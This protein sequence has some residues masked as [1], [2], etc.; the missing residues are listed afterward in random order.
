MVA[1]LLKPTELYTLSGW[2]VWYVNYISVKLFFEKKK[3]FPYII[4]KAAVIHSGQ[5]N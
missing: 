3:N 5:L 2:I 1:H 4:S